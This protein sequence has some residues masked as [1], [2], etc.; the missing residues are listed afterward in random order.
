MTQDELPLAIDPHTYVTVLFR[1]GGMPDIDL[2][3]VW[4]VRIEDGC[5]LIFDFENRTSYRAFPLDVVAEYRVS[6][7]P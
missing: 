5:L 4:G 7:L 2:A 3:L 1:D 6:V